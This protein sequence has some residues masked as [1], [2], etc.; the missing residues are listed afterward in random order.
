[1]DA[2]E[3]CVLSGYKCPNRSTSGRASGELSL[4]GGLT[5]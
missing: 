1:M 4:D 5:G 2:S 3:G